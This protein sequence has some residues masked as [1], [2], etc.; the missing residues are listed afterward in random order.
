MPRSWWPIGQ[1]VGYGV[2]F[3]NQ[4]A[5]LLERWPGGPWEPDLAHGARVQ[6]VCEAMERAAAERRWVG[7]DEVTG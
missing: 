7:V 6:A 3:V 5:D 2:T 1:G 4:A